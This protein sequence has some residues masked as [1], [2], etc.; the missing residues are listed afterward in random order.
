VGKTFSKIFFF[1]AFAYAGKE[2]NNAVQNGT[3]SVIFYI[4]KKRKM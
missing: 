3:V 4:Y 2:E 1:P